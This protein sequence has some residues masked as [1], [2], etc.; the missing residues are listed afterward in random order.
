MALL[1]SYRW[2]TL[3]KTHIEAARSS[4]SVV[5]FKRHLKLAHGD[6]LEKT[7]RVKVET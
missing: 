4:S 3:S 1:Q 6:R 7:T 2:N 5:L